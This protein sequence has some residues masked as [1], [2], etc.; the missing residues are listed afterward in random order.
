MVATATAAQAPPGNAVSTGFGPTVSPDAFRDLTQWLPLHASERR[1]NLVTQSALGDP[2]L[3][4]LERVR[5]LSGFMF[6]VELRRRVVTTLIKTLLPLGLMAL[7]MYASLY[8]PPA[9]VKEKITV[10]ITGALS[11]AVLLS[12]IN[13][14]LGNVGYLLAIEYGFYVFFILCL[15]CI[16][17]VLTAE[18]LRTG[19]R[20]PV[21]AAVERGGRYLFLLGFLGTAAW[22]WF[23]FLRS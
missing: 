16:V 7:I 13:S 10:A 15:L 21:A 17:S 14:Q 1:D 9:L 23:T 18:R 20:H 6:N 19:G 12:S 3:V 11:G 2:R 22:G 4:G 8:F 5:E